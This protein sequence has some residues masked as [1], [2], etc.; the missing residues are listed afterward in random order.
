MKRSPGFTLIEL[1][2]VITIILL[3]TSFGLA[4]QIGFRDRLLVEAT[5]KDIA[6]LMSLA[7]KYARSGNRGTGANCGLSGNGSGTVTQNQILNQTKPLLYWGVKENGNASS[8]ALYICC[9][10]S[11]GE[12]ES[13]PTTTDTIQTLTLPKGITVKTSFNLQFKSL[14]G[15]VMKDQV[16]LIAEENI[17]VSGFDN[18]YSFTVNSGGAISQVSLKP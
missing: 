8:V 16:E 14:W 17:I 3:M 18:K 13:Y 15:G 5:T 7:S 4:N 2:V 9:G 10:T 1:M 12:C 11:Y 6:G